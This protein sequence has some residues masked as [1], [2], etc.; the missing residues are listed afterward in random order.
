MPGATEGRSQNLR[1][2]TGLSYITYFND[3]IV[4]LNTF[5]QALRD[6]QCL[7]IYHIF[8][9]SKP[10]QLVKNVKTFDCTTWLVFG[11]VLSISKLG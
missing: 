6:G 1:T 10:E 3:L 9:I 8:R 2:E 11:I 4:C 7:G 5:G